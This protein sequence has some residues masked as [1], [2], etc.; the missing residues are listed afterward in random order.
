MSA[1]APAQ[2]FDQAGRFEEKHHL[3]G[4]QAFDAAVLRYNFHSKVQR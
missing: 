3:W 1:C 4:F 2:T